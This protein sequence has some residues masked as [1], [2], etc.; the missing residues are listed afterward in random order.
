MSVF[1]VITPVIASSPL[2]ATA[3]A[4]VAGAAGFKIFSQSQAN[5]GSR[6]KVEIPIDE[7]YL[8]NEVLEKEGNIALKRDDMT[9][10]FTRDLRG[11]CKIHLDA[12]NKNEEELKEIGQ[13]TLNKI[14]QQYSHK[15]VISDLESKG[16][17]VSDEE[18]L[19]DGTIKIQVRRWT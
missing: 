11:Q 16:F 10:T 14:L 2:F 12:E 7:N 18:V 9:I 13:N 6:T 17:S 5:S 19:D 1:F 3:I 15:K 8:L 4:S